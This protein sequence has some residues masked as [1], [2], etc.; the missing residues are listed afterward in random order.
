[1]GQQSHQVH[2]TF[3]VLWVG[4]KE[5]SELSGRVRGGGGAGSGLTT[6]ITAG[7]PRIVSVFVVFF[8]V[9]E[10]RLTHSLIRFLIQAMTTITAMKIMS[11]MNNQWIIQTPQLPNIPFNQ[12]PIDQPLLKS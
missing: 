6:A 1:M 9:E 2:S 11:P 4:K 12:V 3:Q 10:H 7:F 8:A 5:K